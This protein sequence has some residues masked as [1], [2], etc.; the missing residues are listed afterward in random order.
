MFNRLSI[1]LVL[2]VS[3]LFTACTKDGMGS[4]EGSF[5]AGGPGAGAGGNG[6]GSTQQ[7]GVITAGEW[8]D[9]RNWTFWT[10]LMDTVRWREMQGKWKFYPREP[11][12]VVLLDN[13]GKP[14]VDATVLL[15]TPN[16]QVRWSSRTDN[17]G[18]AICMPILF[19]EHLQSSLSPTGLLVVARV[20]GTDYPLGNFPASRFLEHRFPF[21]ASAQRTMDIMFVVD[22]TGSMGDEISYLKTELYDVLQRAQGELPGMNLRMGSVFYRDEGDDYVTRPFNFTTKT[23]DLTEFIRKQNADGGGDFPEAVHSALEVAIRQQS[24]SA[25]AQGRLLFLILDAPP[26]EKES[27]IKSLQE[28]IRRAAEMG[29]KVIPVTASG[30]NKETEFLMRFMAIATQGTYVFITNDSGIGNP[31]LSPTVGPYTVEFLNNL[32][33]RLIKQY[34][35]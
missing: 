32:M 1:G 28:S 35:K 3:L 10:Q 19:E 7:P 5:L 9:L 13:A 26:H 14:V 20:N 34:G 24:W 12:Q 4:A 31:H 22:A 2:A 27:V 16:G 6:N 11:L 23:G 18:S 25:Q 21:S 15:R 30:I 33:V 17:A 8:N 29:I